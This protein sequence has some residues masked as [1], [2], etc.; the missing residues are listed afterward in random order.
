MIASASRLYSAMAALHSAL[1]STSKQWETQATPRAGIRPQEALNCLLVQGCDIL[2]GMFWTKLGTDT[3]VAESGTVEEINQFV[4]GGKP[5]ILYFSKRP[6]DPDKID[7]RQHQRLRK[8]KTAT[9]KKALVGSFSRVDELRRTLLRDLVSVV[10][11]LRAQRPSLRGG[12]PQAGREQPDH[13]DHHQATQAQDQSRAVREVPGGTSTQTDENGGRHDGPAA[14]WGA[15]TERRSDWIPPQRR[16]GSMGE[17]GGRAG[18]DHRVAPASSS[19]RPVDLGCLRQVLGQG[20]VEP[21]PELEVS[22]SGRTGDSDQGTEGAL[23]EGERAASRIEKKFGKK[24]LGWGDFEWGLLSGR[25]SALAW[26]MGAEWNESL[27]T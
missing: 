13:R 17:G 14:A 16:Q 8:F 22:N 21:A 25:M 26:V 27:D 15:R 3:G 12:L 11:E 5:A 23:S 19:E 4:A 20:L 7:P 24:N 2:V 9:Y 1:S 6:I 18:K 10:R